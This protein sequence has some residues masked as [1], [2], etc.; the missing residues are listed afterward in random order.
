MSYYFLSTGQSL[1]YGFVNYH[2]QEDATKAI[3]TL[4]G[5]RLQNKTIKVIFQPFLNHTLHK[6]KHLIIFSMTIPSVLAL[7]FQNFLMLEKTNLKIW[8]KFGY[9]LHRILHLSFATVL[10]SYLTKSE[11]GSGHATILS[12]QRDHVFS[13]QSCYLLQYYSIC[14][15]T[16]SGHRNLNI[17]QIFYGPCG[18]ITLSRCRIVVVAKLKNCRVPSNDNNTVKLKSS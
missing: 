7:L 9:F 3:Q 17:F 2:R 4:N 15:A 8:I 12:R 16:P 5:L 11:L 14:L 13:P 6:K 10:S 18:S 1:G